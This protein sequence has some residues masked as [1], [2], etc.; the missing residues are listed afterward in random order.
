MWKAPI[1]PSRSLG[2]LR[3]GPAD[4]VHGFDEAITFPGGALPRGQY[5]DPL[6]LHN[7]REERF[8]GYCMDIFAEAAM[9][10]IEQHR[11]RPFYIASDGHT[12]REWV[13]GTAPLAVD[14]LPRSRFI[15]AV[16]RAIV[17]PACRRP[18]CGKILIA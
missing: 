14:G 8:R 9:K 10:F 5:F 6:L 4:N 13:R 17:R 1:P 3:S 2:W 11:G 12:S 18:S 16:T 15:S 7:S